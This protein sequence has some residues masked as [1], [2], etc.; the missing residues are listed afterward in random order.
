MSPIHALLLVVIL[1]PWAVADEPRRAIDPSRIKDKVTIQL[2]QKLAIR[3]QADGDTLREPK[4]VR[5]TDARPPHITVSFETT[6]AAPFAP[7]R[8]GAKRPFLEV[9][10][11]LERPLTFRLLARDKGSRE[12]FEIADAFEPIAPGEGATKCWDFDS[13]IEEI[14]L[15]EFAQTAPTRE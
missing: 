1:A 14:A 13:R 9:H 10:N 6:S 8:P 2:A 15:I 4:V 11:N 7:P 12:F 3:F 5:P